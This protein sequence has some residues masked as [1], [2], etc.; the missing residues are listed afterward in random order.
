MG[1]SKL[2]I[3]ILIFGGEGG[4]VRKPPPRQCGAHDYP[5]RRAIQTRAQEQFVLDYAAFLRIVEPIPSPRGS[6]TW[7]RVR[8][9]D[10]KFAA[11]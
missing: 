7:R 2:H 1:T 11:E 8:D 3:G 5:H 9:M 10:R 4:M 6:V